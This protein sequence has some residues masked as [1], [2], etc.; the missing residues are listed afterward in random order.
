[1]NKKTK[2]KIDVLA[3]I[4]I[5]IFGIAL[6]P[7]TLQN[8]TFYTIKIG[9][10]IMQNGIDR[11][12]PF[13][14]HD[15]AYTYPHWLYDVCIYL[16]Y[17]VAGMVGIYI[18]TIALTCVLGIAL[19]VTNNKVNKKP[20]FSFI[21]TIVALYMIN[22]FIAA[23]AQLVTYILFVLEILCIEGFLDTK[24]IRYAISSLY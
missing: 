9:E 22:D 5:I 6:A 10:H 12:D 2:M 11:V 14:W 4:C 1:M 8:D 13:S 23:R 3:I 18:S 17:S 20:L 24:K 16:I 19:Y 15:L 21:F 7:K